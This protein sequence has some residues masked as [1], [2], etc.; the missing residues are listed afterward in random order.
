MNVF[1]V[2]NVYIADFNLNFLTGTIP[3]YV[4]KSAKNSIV[5]FQ[6]V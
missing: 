5:Y 6:Q 3:S 4:E 2:T 1:D